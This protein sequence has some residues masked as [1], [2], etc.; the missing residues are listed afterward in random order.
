MPVAAHGETM[1]SLKEVQHTLNCLLGAHLTEDGNEGPDTVRAI[2]CFQ[3]R[4]GLQPDGKCGPKTLHA[5]KVTVARMRLQALPVQAGFG[6]DPTDS[7]Q[8]VQHA[9]NLIGRCKLKENGHL[10]PKTVACV[11][12]FQKSC[13][14]DSDGRVGH[15]TLSALKRCVHE[16]RAR[17]SEELTEPS[18]R[19][20]EVPSV[21]HGF[22]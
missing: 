2:K 5:L 4:V 9:L 12:A 11:K 3:A 13:G 7:V 18:I 20:Y 6:A 8:W 17:F 21:G 14:L 19:N 15:M 1:S 22:G 16:K 10:G